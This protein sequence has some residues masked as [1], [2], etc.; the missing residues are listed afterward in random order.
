MS[1]ENTMIS[2]SH[3]SD[4]IKFKVLMKIVYVWQSV[5]WFRHIN[6][7]FGISNKIEDVHA[8]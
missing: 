7:K 8:F 6:N 3:T 4:Y 2:S 1:F 5:N